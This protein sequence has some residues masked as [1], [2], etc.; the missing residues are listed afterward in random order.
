MNRVLSARYDVPVPRYAS[1]PTAPHW[2]DPP[3]TE[4]WLDALRGAL[5]DAD[6][7][8]AL[9]IHV[10]FCESLCTFC[11]CNTIITQDHGRESRYIALLLT[12]WARYAREVPALLTRGLRQIHLG[13]GTPTFLSAESLRALL[14]PILEPLSL[15]RDALDAS[16]EVNPSVTG[17]AQLR[18][19]G[20]LGFSRVSMGVQDFD[21]TVQRLINRV[22]PFEV[23]ERLTADARAMGY[24]SVSYD[25]IY[26][27]PGQ[28]PASARRTAALTVQ[29]APDRVAL[30]GFARAPWIHPAERL[31]TDGDLPEGAARRELYEIAR[32]TFLEAGYVEIGPE[33][34]ALPRDILCRAQRSGELHRNFVGYTEFRTAVLLGIGV[35]AISETPS[36]LHQNEKVEPI[37][38]RRIDAGEIPTLRGHRLSADDARARRQ[39]TTLMTGF[40]V[41][42]EE[43][44]LA[45][46]RA[47]LAPMIADGLVRIAEGELQ[48]TGAGRPFLRNAAVFFD[49]RLRAIE[50]DRPIVSN[51]PTRAVSAAGGGSAAR[52]T[53]HEARM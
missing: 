11:G 9:Y 16:V 1:Y 31:F 25:L 42:L 37:Y 26:G 50:P 10:P 27:L 3:G 52:A 29:L 28:T 49:H 21:D 6:R 35:S 14:G 5:A 34:F 51:A 44:Q 39:I 13:G 20:E 22:Q 41:R 12:E 45:D 19:L 7:T 4:Q 32:E 47:F 40:R 48:L 2:S 53:A 36:C 23:T 8:W 33:Q 38:A 24:E 43:D 15:R 17:A 18:V 30:Y 46:A